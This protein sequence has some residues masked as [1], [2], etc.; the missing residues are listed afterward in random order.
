MRIGNRNE[1]RQIFVFTHKADDFEML[2][3][4]LQRQPILPAEL[5]VVDI[6]AV[7]REPENEDDD[8]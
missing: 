7:L 4:L 8:N 5:A 6:R 3:T 2:E 1:S